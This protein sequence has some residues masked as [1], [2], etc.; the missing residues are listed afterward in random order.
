MIPGVSSTSAIAALAVT[1]LAVT[2]PAAATTTSA[3]TTT[4][5]PTTTT[6]PVPARFVAPDG[7]FAITLPGVP[8]ATADA[9]AGSDAFTIGVGEDLV[10]VTRYPLDAFDGDPA[11]TTST[12][13]DG[14]LDASGTVV[15]ELARVDTTLWSYPA[16]YFIDELALDTGPTATLYGVA[17]G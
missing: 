16:T 11:A 8:A 12:R 10:A 9:D 7:T 13:V 4:A 15:E 14:L 17:V 1:V 5:P 2:V 6:P 3:P